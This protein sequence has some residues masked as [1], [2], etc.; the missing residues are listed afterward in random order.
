MKQRLHCY[1]LSGTLPLK[2]AFL[3]S[4]LTWFLQTRVI[5]SNVPTHVKSLKHDEAKV[6]NLNSAANEITGSVELGSST[7]SFSEK[8]TN[9]KRKEVKV[10]RF[11]YLKISTASCFVRKRKRKNAKKKRP[12]IEKEM[13]CRFASEAEVDWSKESSSKAEATASVSGIIKK[14]FSDYDEVA[15]SP[16]F[17]FTPMQ[18]TNSKKPSFEAS[19]GNHKNPEVGERLLHASNSLRLAPGN[20]KSVLSL[21]HYNYGESPLHK[22]KATV[23]NLAFE[24][25]DEGD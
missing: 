20:R 13:L 17:P 7:R 25:A 15:S 3:G 11:P 1:H 18:C 16:Y 21:C 22:F 6:Q 4:N 24:I 2:F 19:R 23:R 5:L 9:C 8:R 14:Y 10:H 12:K